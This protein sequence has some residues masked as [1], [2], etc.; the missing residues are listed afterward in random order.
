MANKNIQMKHKTSSGWDVLLPITHIENVLDDNGS[1]VS[2][3][4]IEVQ[5]DANAAVKSINTVLPS[6]S[7]NVNMFK[8]FN[9]IPNASEFNQMSEGELGFII[10]SITDVPK[11]NS[12]NSA[13]DPSNEEPLGNLR[14]PSSTYRLYV[15]FTPSQTINMNRLVTKMIAEASDGIQHIAGDAIRVRVYAN[16]A[17]TGLLGTG[18]VLNTT[19]KNK[20]PFDAPAEFDTPVTLTAGTKYYFLYDIPTYT[21]E[22]SYKLLGSTENNY[23]NL[24]R[25]YE[26]SSGFTEDALDPYIQV[27]GS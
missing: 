9:S 4:L 15:A 11:F 5:S 16:D 27:Y 10:D 3:K 14:G 18:T 22:N 2:E 20:V 19:T 8:V 21:D 13:S 23:S 17:F 24:F 7:G 25:A 1:T 6:P 12:Y 26:R